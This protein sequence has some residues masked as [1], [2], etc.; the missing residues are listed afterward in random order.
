MKLIKVV[1]IV[2]RPY[3][4]EISGDQTL[5]WLNQYLLLFSVPTLKVHIAQLTQL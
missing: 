3:D 4:D 1:Q 2:I 5:W